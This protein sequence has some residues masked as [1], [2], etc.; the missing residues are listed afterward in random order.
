M[1]IPR[2]GKV[3]SSYPRAL[4]DAQ[5]QNFAPAIAETIRQLGGMNRLLYELTTGFSGDAD[6]A[7]ASPRNGQS[8]TGID[9]SG[10]PFGSSP[11]HVLAVWVPTNPVA[12]SGWDRTGKI[13][14]QENNPLVLDGV[15]EVR[16]HAVFDGC[17][18]S[19]GYL[20]VRMDSTVASTNVVIT[21]VATGRET[22][23]VQGTTTTSYDVDDDGSADAFYLDL[24]PGR[25]RVQLMLTTAHNTAVVTCMFAMLA[26]IAKREHTRA[27]IND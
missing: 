12:S 7:P 13:T 17:P 27:A 6:G 4:T 20:W 14:F 3:I 24:K 8:T 11:R 22:T 1:T 2:T 21:D 5:T 19:R 23:I 10:P 26:N 16:G 18:L 25:N 15:I 9:H